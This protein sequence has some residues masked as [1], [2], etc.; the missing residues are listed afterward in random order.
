[1]KSI[2]KPWRLGCYQMCAC[3][4]RVVREYENQKFSS[5]C[6]ITQNITRSLDILTHI[7]GSPSDI[8]T[9]IHKYYDDMY[10]YFFDVSPYYLMNLVYN[11]PICSQAIL[12]DKTIPVSCANWIEETVL[13]VNG[14]IY[15][16]LNTIE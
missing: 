5:Q 12:N 11:N 8:D 7:N 2:H 14:I 15:I 4:I 9:E 10:E 16:Y 13:A 1:M 3:M 6:P